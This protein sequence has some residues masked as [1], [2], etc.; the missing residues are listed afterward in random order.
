MLR[1]VVT[2]FSDIFDERIH[3][4]GM[5]APECKIEVKPGAVLKHSGAPHT[6][7]RKK[8][9]VAKLIKQMLRG[10]VIVKI[11]N[12]QITS[13]MLLVEKKDTTFRLVVNYKA[14]NQQTKAYSYPLPNTKE[15]IHNVGGHKY[16]GVIDARS[17]YWQLPLQKQSQRLTAFRCHKGTFAFT[18]CPMGFKNSAAYYQQAMEFVLGDLVDDIC[19]V[20]QDDII[21]VGDTQ[22]EFVQ[23]LRRVFKR[24]NEHNVRLK[25]SKAKLGLTELDFLGYR[26]S[27][28]GHEPTLA[29]KQG[30]LNLKPPRTTSQARTYCGLINFIRS[31]LPSLASIV[32]PITSLCSPNK[33]FAWSD[34]CQ[35]AFDAVRGLIEQ[36]SILYHADLEKQLYIRTD[37]SDVG[38]GAFLYQRDADNSVLPIA[39]ASWKWSGAQLNYGIQQ[40][41]LLAAVKALKEFKHLAWGADVVLMIDNANLLAC[42]ESSNP[43]VQRWAF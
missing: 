6:N 17:G 28:R 31:W 23:N 19:W 4:E 14:L 27:S 29:Y 7:K 5:I 21:C 8:K 42:M 24:L 40:K 18:K 38:G 32:A 33:P 22:E 2:E 36:A 15:L 37:A 13:P 34:E 16:Y 11:S 20:Y 25:A 26:L 1:N 43:R 12:P 39:F 41:E 30:L 3:P 35:N 10:N 9:V